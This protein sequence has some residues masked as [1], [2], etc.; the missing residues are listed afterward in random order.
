M[1][2]APPSEGARQRGNYFVSRR[3]WLLY[4]D[5]ELYRSL[6]VLLFYET[7]VKH[8]ELQSWS[9]NTSQPNQLSSNMHS[10]RILSLEGYNLFT[11]ENN[12]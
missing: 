8:L 9:T 11:R 3:N 4:M 5:Y 7:G 12:P 1:F 2:S 10:K 6:Q